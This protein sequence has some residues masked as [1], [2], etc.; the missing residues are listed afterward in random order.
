MLLKIYLYTNFRFAD[1]ITQKWH[2]SSSKGEQPVQQEFTVDRL[3]TR[4]QIFGNS[5]ERNLGTSQHSHR[6]YQAL[7]ST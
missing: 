6:L 7:L 1:E 4:V 2:Q 3:F 5:F